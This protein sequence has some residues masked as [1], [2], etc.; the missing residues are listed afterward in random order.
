MNWCKHSVFRA[1]RVTFFL[2]LEIKPNAS[3]VFSKLYSQPQSLLGSTCTWMQEKAMQSFKTI[4]NHV[5]FGTNP[6]EQTAMS[7]SVLAEEIT[8]RITLEWS[9]TCTHNSGEEPHTCPAFNPCALPHRSHSLGCMCACIWYVLCTFYVLPRLGGGVYVPVYKP[10][11]SVKCL[12]SF[13]TF[14][15]WD[16]LCH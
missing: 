12:F 7:V 15:S 3:L 13:S 9:P 10:E 16:R 14:T 2:M 11:V 8:Q 1:S 6:E 4:T 5:S